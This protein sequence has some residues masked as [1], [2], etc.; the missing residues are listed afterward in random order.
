MIPCMTRQILCESAGWVLFADGRRLV[1]ADRGTSH[2]RVL[3]FV[4]A[5][6]IYFL[7]AWPLSLVTR[8]VEA[9]MRRGLRTA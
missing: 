2:R 9:R 3:L 5:G 4:L 6:V 8:R 7:M 1:F